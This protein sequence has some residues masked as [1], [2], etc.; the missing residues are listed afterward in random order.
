MQSVV[1]SPVNIYLHC[2]MFQTVTEMKE[3]VGKHL[4]DNVLDRIPIVPSTGKASSRLLY[5]PASCSDG[6]VGMKISLF[7]TLTPWLYCVAITHACH[8][9]A[10]ILNICIDVPV[11]PWSD[12]SYSVPSGGGGFPVEGHGCF[13]NG[14]QFFA[15]LY[16]SPPPFSLP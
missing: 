16:S 5:T 12:Y 7:K 10:T 8:N 14:E 9:A 2:V 6:F 11:F 4:C 13:M 3:R 1:I 15:I